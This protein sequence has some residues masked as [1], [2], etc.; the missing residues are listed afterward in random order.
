M[1]RTQVQHCT[2][3]DVP[4]WRPRSPWVPFLQPFLQVRQAHLTHEGTKPVQ[5]KICPLLPQRCSHRAQHHWPHLWIQVGRDF[6]CRLKKKNS[7]KILM[8]HKGL[9]MQS[10]KQSFICLCPSPAIAT[11]NKYFPVLTL[12][13]PV[14]FLTHFDLH[15]SLVKILPI[16]HRHF[17]IKKRA[18]ETLIRKMPDRGW[19]ERSLRQSKSPR[20]LLGRKTGT[21]N[22]V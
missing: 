1:G 10:I 22:K 12:C 5:N 21:E 19:T 17:K 16:N 20:L 11:F 4:R 2:S 8:H 9:N 15:V 14:I 3:V 18:P 13:S 7:Y 6:F